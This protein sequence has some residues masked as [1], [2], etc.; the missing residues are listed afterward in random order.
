[1]YFLFIHGTISKMYELVTYDQNDQRPSL[2][3]KLFLKVG[4]GGAVKFR[5]RLCSISCGSY[6]DLQSRYVSLTKR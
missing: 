5:T 4:H 1:M 2:S 6:C 3:P